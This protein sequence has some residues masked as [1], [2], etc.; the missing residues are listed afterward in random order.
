MSDSVQAGGDSPESAARTPEAAATPPPQH[1]EPATVYSDQGAGPAPGRPPA[2]VIPG[3]EVL[4]ELGRG[5]MGV[6]FKA[7]E[8]ALDRLVA[9]K[10]IQGPAAPAGE[11]VLRLLAE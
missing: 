5:G 9:L 7:R 11:E 4:G 2:P 6:V 8:T 10:M 1:S 3:Y